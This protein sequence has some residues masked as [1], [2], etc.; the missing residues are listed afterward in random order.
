LW[1]ATSSSASITLADATPGT[2]LY[3]TLD[4]SDS[5]T[6]SILYTGSFNLTKQ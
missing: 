5:D 4:G 6:N 3:Y 1:T 2:S